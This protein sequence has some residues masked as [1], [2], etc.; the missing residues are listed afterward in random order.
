M[1]TAKSF[2]SRLPVHW[3]QAIL[4]VGLAQALVEP[5]ILG[6]GSVS[7][8]CLTL[9]LLLLVTEDSARGS[10][11]VDNRDSEFVH[12]W[13]VSTPCSDSALG[14]SR[15]RACRAGRESP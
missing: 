5:R 2:R 7:A 9:S 4:Y 8:A 14:T 6:Y 11:P 13:S 1:A 3:P 10:G 15:D 12:R